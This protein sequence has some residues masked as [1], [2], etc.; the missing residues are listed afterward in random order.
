M[1]PKPN[2]YWRFD[3]IATEAAKKTYHANWRFRRDDF[4]GALLR[5]YWL[6]FPEN[7][8]NQTPVFG[9]AP[10]DYSPI[11]RDVVWRMLGHYNKP[12]N[13][14]HVLEGDEPPYEKLAEASVEDFRDGAI[15]VLRNLCLSEP[16][17]R[18]WIERH[19]GGLKKADRIKGGRNGKRDQGLQQVVDWLKGKVE[20]EGQKFTPGNL[21]DW[22]EMN[23]SVN[24][25]GKLVTPFA[26][27][28]ELEWDGNNL[29][30]IDS[31]GNRQKRAGR[32]LEP[33]VRQANTPKAK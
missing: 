5:D 31:E 19:S 22:V 27:C 28:D 17:A 2:D 32:S 16:N 4:L 1:R 12:E 26:G 23:A 13:V 9:I 33:Y 14:Q 15:T 29:H 8:P 24:D 10:I 3:K 20:A 11:K 30:W 6:G 25:D 7:G 21:C 18:D